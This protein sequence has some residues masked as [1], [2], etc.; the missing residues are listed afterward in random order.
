MRRNTLPVA[1]LP[2]LAVLALA[3]AAQRAT[4][5]GSIIVVGNEPF[6]SVAIQ[7]SK[8]AVYRVSAPPRLE[9]RLRQVQ[10]MKILAEY[11]RIDSTAEGMRIVITKFQTL[12]H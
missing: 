4:I 2:C 6:T 3:C 10:G 12:A 9:Q 11:S 1:F 7:T 8:G 5:E